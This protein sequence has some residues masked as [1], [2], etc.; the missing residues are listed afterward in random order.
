MAP[1]L[2]GDIKTQ[3]TPD[4][5][6]HLSSV[7]GESPGNTQKAVDEVLPTLLAGVMNFSSSGSG[8][9]QLVDLITHGDYGPVL[10]N[11]SAC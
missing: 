7:L 1:S 3:L 6:H 4:M 5:V 10:N 8:A 9:T 11:L 2:L